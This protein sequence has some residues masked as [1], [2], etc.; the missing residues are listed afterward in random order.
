MGMDIGIRGNGHGQA[1]GAA[2]DAK[3]GTN[4]GGA[5]VA[6][7]ADSVPPLEEPDQPFEREA[8]LRPPVLP[9]GVLPP[10]PAPP[11]FSFPKAVSRWL[12]EASGAVV[13]FT[14]ERIAFF[15]RGMNDR[16][17]GI[18]T[19]W[20]EKPLPLALFQLAY[21][22]DSLER[23]NL[24]YPYPEGTLVAFQDRNQV[25]PPATRYFRTP[26]G[27]WNDAGNPREGSANVRFPRN[28]SADAAH[29]EQMPQL[30]EPNPALVSEA[31]LARKD[32]KMHEVPFLNLLAASWIQFMV[33]DWVSHR[34]YRPDAGASQ[35]IPVTLPEGHVGR[36]AFRDG[37]MPVGKTMPDPTHLPSEGGPAT[38]INEVTSWWDGSQLY[39]SDAETSRC[40]RSRV[41]G[42]LEIDGEFLPSEG[43]V[44]R[45]GYNKNWWVGLSM[46][47]TLFVR[48]HNAI[49]D[50]LKKHHPTWDD[51]RLFEVAR[52]VN[53]A[54]MAKIH[55]VEWTPAIL[56]NRT[57]KIAMETN[58]YGL[59]ESRLHRRN[60]KVLRR[61]KVA[62]GVIGGLVGGKTQKHGAPYGLSE[63]FVEV[64]RLHELLPDSV[65]VHALD[66]K[67]ATELTLEQTRLREVPALVRKHGMSALFYSFG[68]Q[69]P[70]GIVLHNYP[71]TLRTLRVPGSPSLDLASVDILRSRERGVPRYNAFRKQ[72]GLR[73]IT[74]FEDLTDDEADLQ[75]LRSVYKNV[76]EIDMAV[77]TRAET[78]R[79]EKFGFGETLFQI[80]ILNASRRLQ[81]DR[82]FT[83]SYNAETYTQE[84]LDWIDRATF[85]SVL[86][87]H[88]P[89][90]R[91]TGLARVDNAF[92]PW[93]M[94]PLTEE[95]HPLRYADPQNPIHAGI[96]VAVE[97]AKDAARFARSWL[98]S[99]LETAD[100]AITRARSV[101]NGARLSDQLPPGSFG[102]PVFGESLSYVGN[103]GPFLD[104]RVRKYGSVFKTHIAF[105]PT[106]CFGGKE[107]YDFF[108]SRKDLFSRVNG[109]PRNVEWLFDKKSLTFQDGPA[110]ERVQ[111]LL[112]AA[113]E[114]D[115]LRTYLPVM[116]QLF[117]NSIERCA[118][119]KTFHWLPEI[120]ALAFALID[121]VFMGAAPEVNRS[122]WTRAFDRLTG[123][124]VATPFS[125]K[126]YWALAHRL[127]FGNYVDG[128]I[129][130]RINV[131]G[132]DVVSR[133]LAGDGKDKLTVDELKVELIHFF[134][135]GAPLESALAYHLLF[136]A[137]HP[138]VMEKAR[139]EVRRIAPAGDV[140]LEQFKAMTYVLS[141]CKESRRAARLV[142]NTFF[143][144]VT[145]SFEYGSYMIPAGW[146]AMGL[147]AATQ[148]DPSAF[149]KPEEYD[150]DRFD[151]AALAASGTC[152][153]Y[154][155]H[156]GEKDPHRCIGERFTD[157]VMATLTAR[158]LQDYTWSLLP[159]QDLSPRFGKVA[160]VPAGGLQVVLHRVR[161]G[162]PAK[163][164]ALRAPPLPV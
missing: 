47:H 92:E 17:E 49:C 152:P 28:V 67:P 111:R 150:P 48:E 63:E 16:S 7:C 138:D 44:E 160:P 156:G 70:G 143:A 163:D 154:V 162:P 30:L 45:V 158:L 33:H 66:G 84:G 78:E 147:I 1:G 91:E 52:L 54:V 153:M 90:L 130:R 94:G 11:P 55:T 103:S 34:T 6:Y 13:D 72:L 71:T 106:V 145:R 32:G 40:L 60:R 100:K 10:P 80:F 117:T 116:N 101:T 58:W 132:N 119:V 68:I 4:G 93:D 24:K 29:G 83:E 36:E 64:Y 104:E 43:G 120:E 126:L 25:P 151:P 125:P 74:R 122:F 112:L 62:N 76:D 107:A 131:P 12:G 51:A 27:S 128:V 23:N 127:L 155:A 123:G 15:A 82:F 109:A 57:L 21:M 41:D 86:L 35:T 129:E 9:H 121:C 61:V 42:K 38:T 37:V 8:I 69:H 85:K 2:T 79:P 118:E 96:E 115:A 20:D 133:L 135:A 19:N 99:A 141:T 142:P 77:G 18:W 137:R 14:W 144:R 31:L 98:G 102:L 65:R 97:A 89:E 114:D 88:Y 39:G 73:P 108:V 140:T 113:F 26:D 5:S 95:R 159:D 75:A 134:L 146:R 105:Q 157:L 53:T 139:A 110:T 148:H 124:V 59:L 50:E 22:R 81:A 161:T 87:R 46:L 149:P 164:P 136:L 3:R 56:P